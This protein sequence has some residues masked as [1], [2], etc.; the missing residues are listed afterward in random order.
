ME[1]FCCS[2]NRQIRI[3]QII[4]KTKISFTKKHNRTHYKKSPSGKWNTKESKKKNN[5]SLGKSVLPLARHISTYIKAGLLV[6]VYTIHGLIFI[7]YWTKIKMFVKCIWN[8]DD[9]YWDIFRGISKPKFSYTVHGLLHTWFAK[10]YTYYSMEYLIS[11][12]LTMCNFTHFIV[13]C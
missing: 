2:H 13:L 12:E 11:H 3:F 1:I 9:T 7:Y 6:F 4:Y 10:L 8:M 5:F